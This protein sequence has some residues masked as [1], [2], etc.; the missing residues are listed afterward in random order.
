MLALQTA[1]FTAGP[2][3]PRTHCYSSAGMTTRM[4]S[5]AM[6]EHSDVSDVGSARGAGPCGAGADLENLVRTTAFSSASAAATQ[7]VLAT[8]ATFI[9]IID[10]VRRSNVFKMTGRAVQSFPSLL[11]FSTL[12]GSWKW[13]VDCSYGPYNRSL[14]QLNLSRIVGSTIS[15]ACI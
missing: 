15:T 2:S 4:V 10:E 5:R 9:K 12:D 13:G 6:D 1:G 7:G 8:D 3:L 11:Y 14:V